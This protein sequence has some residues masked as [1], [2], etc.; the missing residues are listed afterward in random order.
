MTDEKDQRD[1][2][3]PRDQPE[4][5]SPE[6]AAWR[7]WAE[8]MRMLDDVRGQVLPPLLA[9]GFDAFNNA[10]GRPDVAPLVKT[11]LL[12][13]GPLPPW[14]RPAAIETVE[15]PPLDLLRAALFYL[16]EV[17]LPPRVVA[18]GFPPMGGWL[19]TGLPIE[20][21][22][23]ASA[24]IGELARTAV[25]RRGGGALESAARLLDGALGHYIRYRM[26][27]ESAAQESMALAAA[28]ARAFESIQ[29]GARLG[30]VRS[31]LRT[32]APWAEL[33]PPPPVDAP[34]VEH[35]PEATAPEPLPQPDPDP[36][37]EKPPL[38][39]FKSWIAKVF[40]RE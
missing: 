26:G 6:L 30:L 31:V 39:R 27:A 10:L 36:A 17:A 34:P 1:P 35:A 21:V 16:V 15:H 5:V 20:Q 18:A 25:E 33:L 2:R 13:L 40:S 8:T 12:E 9:Q 3:D 23:T 11:M 29:P 32:W 7:L 24:A 14:V 4:A 22:Q 38:G 37:P 19:A 28:A